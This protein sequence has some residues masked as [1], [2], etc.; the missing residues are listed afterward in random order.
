MANRFEI[1]TYVPNTLFTLFC[2]ANIVLIIHDMVHPKYPDVRIYTDDVKNIEFPLSFRLCIDQRNESRFHNFGY[3]D[4][5]T[6][7]RGRSVY[8]DSVY[9]WFGHRMNGSTFG[10]PEVK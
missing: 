10:G 8:N 1:L 5:T 6:F 9:G 4:L 3:D 7:Y 2:I